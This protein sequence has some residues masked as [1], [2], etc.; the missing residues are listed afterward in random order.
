[1]LVDLD[2]H[3]VTS[4]PGLLPSF[5]SREIADLKENLRNKHLL[6]SDIDLIRPTRYWHIQEEIQRAFG[7]FMESLLNRYSIDENLDN[8]GRLDKSKLKNLLKFLKQVSC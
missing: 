6:R 2:R 4:P 8:R 1:M 7:N 3:R 5:P